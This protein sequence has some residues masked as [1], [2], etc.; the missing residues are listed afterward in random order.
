[1]AITPGDYSFHIRF[2][3]VSISGTFSD[4][5]MD[6]KAS[7]IINLWGVEP[8]GCSSHCNFDCV[9]C[10]GVLETSQRQGSIFNM[11]PMNIL[12]GVTIAP[13]KS[14]VHDSWWDGPGSEAWAIKFGTG[15]NIWD[16]L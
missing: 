10:L 15:H 5:V 8:E 12:L 7:I 1:M 6:D 16:R 4:D 9:I 11:S 14:R 3:S 2:I 13:E